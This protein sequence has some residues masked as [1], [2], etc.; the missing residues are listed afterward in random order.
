MQYW[1]LKEFDYEPIDVENRLIETGELISDEGKSMNNNPGSGLVYPLINAYAALFPLD[2]LELKKLETTPTN[3][4]FGFRIG[5]NYNNKTKNISWSFDL[6]NGTIIT[7]SENVSLGPKEEVFVYFENVYNDGNIYEINS[8]AYSGELSDSE[9]MTTPIGNVVAYGLESIFQQ[10]MQRVFRFI[11]L[12][13]FGDS[14]GFNWT[15]ETGEGSL[16]GEES[17]Y[18]GTGDG[19]FV[20]VAQNYSS[21]GAFAVNASSFN[22][23][24]SDSAGSIEIAV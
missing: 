12:N 10:S 11:T 1:T 21:P 18:L 19:V 14:T 24:V 9:T 22:E 2:V 6:G 5:N 15:M 20:Y 7:S 3:N 4:I 17:V 8:T 13:N 16:S 23:S